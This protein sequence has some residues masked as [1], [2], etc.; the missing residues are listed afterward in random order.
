MIEHTEDPLIFNAKIN[1]AKYKEMPESHKHCPFCEVTAL[2]AILATDSDKI[3]LK[4]K[5]PTI[6]NAL[7]TVVIESDVHDSDISTNT[8]AQNRDIF[9]F[10]LRCWQDMLTDARYQSVLMFK[11][12]GPRS[13]GTLRH[14]HLQ[15]VGLE[16][17]DGYEQISKE[18]FSGLEVASGVTIST[19]PVMGFIET[20]VSIASA[21]DY[22][23]MA[24]RVGAITHYLMTDFLSGRC[25]SYNLFFYKLDA[26][27][28]CKIVPR[29]ITSPYFIGY[30]IP[31]VQHLERLEEVAADLR[32]I[33]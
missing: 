31:Q 18:N 6:E 27:M 12:F 21:D 19:K 16:D 23:L 33:L 30:K 2:T 8:P 17:V 5:F 11:N 13:G 9:R 28:I 4:N 1:Q 10:A 7:M 14:P 26:Q 3:W 20:N 22:A 32:K 15:I 29:F 24:D 25:D